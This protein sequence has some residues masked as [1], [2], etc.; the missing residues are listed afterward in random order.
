MHTVWVQLLLF[1]CVFVLSSYLLSFFRILTLLGRLLGIT[2]ES[3]MERSDFTY[4][5]EQQEERLE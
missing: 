5:E 1:V 3:N 2:D 4:G